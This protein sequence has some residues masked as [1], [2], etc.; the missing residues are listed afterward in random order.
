MPIRAANSDLEAVAHSGCQLCADIWLVLRRIPLLLVAAV[1][2]VACSTP[3]SED[4]GDEAA[5]EQLTG[6]TIEGPLAGEVD[7]GD[8]ELW[9]GSPESTDGESATSALLAHL[10]TETL[11]ATGADVVDQTGLGGSLLLRDALVSGEIDMYWEGTGV[12]WTGILRE[13]GD[14]LDAEEVYAELSSRDMTENGVAWLEPASF[15]QSRGFAMAEDLASELGIDTIGEMAD[16]IERSDDDLVVCVTQDFI[17]FPADGRVDFEDTLGVELTDEMLRVYDAVPIYPDTGRGQCTFGEVERTSGRIPQ[18]GL[19]LLEDDVGLFQPNQPALA[20]REDVLVA[21]PELSSV[22]A[23]LSPRLTTE[24]IQEMNR[25]VIVEG[26]RPED[27]ARSWV[28]SEGLV[29]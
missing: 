3:S 8:A 26:D 12:A 10:V 9:V 2:L 27:V 24:V 22:L 14:S 15:E 11:N 19:R 1:V 17:T 7:L 6:T 21:H 28:R 18:Y 5:L 20:V 29:E 4:K 23:T 25:R 13:A 16:H